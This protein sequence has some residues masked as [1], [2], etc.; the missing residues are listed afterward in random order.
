MSSVEMEGWERHF[1]RYPPGHLQAEMTAVLIR[2]VAGMFAKNED[3][4]PALEDLCPWIE[5][6]KER[7]AKKDR[8]EKIIKAATAEATREAFKRWKASK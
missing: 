1:A 5:P 4:I 8:R 7:K 2:A 3:D 6:S